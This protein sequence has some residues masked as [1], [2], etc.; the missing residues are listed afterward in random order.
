MQE[1]LT[2]AVRLAGEA[3]AVIRA[4]RADGFAVET[5]TDATPVTLADR[6]A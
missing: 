2:L 1:L 6:R 4:I 3:A 5:K